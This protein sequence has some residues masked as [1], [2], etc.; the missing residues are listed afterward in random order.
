M[1]KTEL[2]LHSAEVSD[3]GRAYVND[4]VD[5][6]EKNGYS[7]VVLC[8]HMSEYTYKSTR[9]GA[10][11]DMTWDQK[12]DF[13]LDGYYKLKE[14]AKGRFNVLLGMELRFYNSLNDYLVYGVTEDFLRSNGDLMA[15]KNAKNLRPFIDENNLLLFQA[16]P[17]R[18]NMQVTDPKYLD[19]VETFNGHPH[20]DSRND[21]A[22]AWADKFDLLRS[23]GSDFHFPAQTPN[24]GILTDF[25]IKD[26]DTLVSTLKNGQF[27][28]I[29]GQ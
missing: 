13:Y 18:N 22:T 4:I 28:L 2:H 24:A 10:S 25:E 11:L 6:Y 27:M 20:H 23:S 7:T 5:V 9:N 19:G 12:V 16:H 17:F 1:F 26:N 29:T 15:L 14:A 3:C 8:N 21:I